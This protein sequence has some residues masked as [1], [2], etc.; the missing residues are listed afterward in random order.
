[1]PLA[2]EMLSELR[3]RGLYTP[4]DKPPGEEDDQV[5]ETQLGTAVRS[6]NHYDQLRRES[7]CCHG[8]GDR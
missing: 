6:E 7:N 4:R 8:G 1:M 5:L 2:E 3:E